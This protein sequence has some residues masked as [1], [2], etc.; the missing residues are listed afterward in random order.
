MPNQIASKTAMQDCHAP[1]DIVVAAF[2]NSIA[3]T[4]AA[5]QE[6]SRTASQFLMIIIK[7]LVNHFYGFH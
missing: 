6:P 1:S 7:I 5:Y 4:P 3:A 2:L